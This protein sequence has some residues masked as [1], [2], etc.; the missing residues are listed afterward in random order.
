MFDGGDSEEK[1]KRKDE[2]EEIIERTQDDEAQ[3]KEEMN[4]MAKGFFE[5]IEILRILGGMEE[6]GVF[7]IVIWEYTKSFFNFSEDEEDS[8][9][10]S[11][12]E[13][14]E[15]DEDA[16]GSEDG[17]EE[18][19]DS[20]DEGSGGGGGGGGSGSSAPDVR[21]S[22]GALTEG[23]RETLNNMEYRGYETPHV[24]GDPN[25][26]VDEDGPWP[27][28][29]DFNQDARKGK[30]PTAASGIL[31][32]VRENPDWRECMLEAL[33]AYPVYINGEPVQ[34]PESMMWAII[35]LESGGKTGA[36]SPTGCKGV[37]QFSWDTYRSVSTNV[38]GAG[39]TSW[40]GSSEHWEPLIDRAPHL[41]LPDSMPDS[42]TE[43]MDK[44]YDPMVGIWSL[45][46]LTAYHCNK[47]DIDPRRMDAGHICYAFHHNG[48]GS[49]NKLLDGEE[50]P[51]QGPHYVKVTEERGVSYNHLIN[52]LAGSV[53]AST[54]MIDQTFEEAGVYEVR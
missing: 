12:D 33:E 20:D 53:T 15:D 43:S 7:A 21:V 25:F 6:P 36:E 17:A 46:A 19:T 44:R 42:K 2:I 4:D 22:G 13:D 54:A 49:A 9:D 41:D 52:G 8:E 38:N 24:E 51:P 16:D 37:A 23:D 30:A 28:D 18:D 29:M 11:E 27:I 35:W 14:L 34:I 47:Y 1:E 39:A 5:K 3:L 26:P 45:V 32:V 48:E 50:V 31:N 40:T 10:D